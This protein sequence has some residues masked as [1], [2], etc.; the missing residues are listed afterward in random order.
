MKHVLNILV[1]SIVFSLGII[2][3]KAGN[4]IG[5]GGSLI[6]QEFIARGYVVNSFLMALPADKQILT[7]DQLKRLEFALIDTRVEVLEEQLFDRFGTPV[8][9]RTIDDPRRAGRKMIQ[10][11]GPKWKEILDSLQGV[12]RLVFHEYLW[13]IGLDDTNYVI[14][15]RADFS[16]NVPSP[17]PIVR[18]CGLSGTVSER[19]RHC[20]RPVEQGGFEELATRLHPVAT[21]NDPIDQFDQ[22]QFH[23]WRLVSRNAERATVW[24]DEASGLM[25]ADIVPTGEATLSDAYV[26]C[27]KPNAETIGINQRFRIPLRSDFIIAISHGLAAVLPK[28]TEQALW[29]AT[30]GDDR[31]FSDTLALT[32]TKEGGYS[33][34]DYYRV[35]GIVK[36]KFSCVSPSVPVIGP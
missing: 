14:S 35:A 29:A 24:R 12:Y 28:F 23:T 10:L 26:Y 21:S 16:A 11:N 20:A 2:Q 5:N 1:A 27:S 3:A 8:D 17:T 33:V 36:H 9:A 13:V 4:E 19:I 22:P 15:R 31:Y 18:T 25:W 6:A 30:L 7:T 32:V 34:K